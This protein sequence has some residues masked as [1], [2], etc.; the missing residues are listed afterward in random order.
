[1]NPWWQ[2]WARHTVGVQRTLMEWRNEHARHPHNSSSPQLLHFIVGDN[3][4]TS[5]PHPKGNPLWSRS[6]SHVGAELELVPNFMPDFLWYEGH[7]SH[8]SYINSISVGKGFGKKN[9]LWHLKR[10]EPH[11]DQSLCQDWKGTIL[12]YRGFRQTSHQ[13]LFIIELPF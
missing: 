6:Q 10:T 11:G 3:E 12:W 9:L 8:S 13:C 7:L 1:M 5:S 2:T 4:P